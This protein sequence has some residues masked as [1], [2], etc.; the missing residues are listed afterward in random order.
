[1]ENLFVN[2]EQALA[3][4]ELGYISETFGF[5]WTDTT[6]LVY[7]NAIGNHSGVHLPVPLYQQAFKWF[8]KPENGSLNHL[9]FMCEFLKD[10]S[11]TYEQA[12][13]ASLNKLIEIIKTK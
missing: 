10:D 8:R 1:M 4:R 7:D 13:L 3:L 11:V 5:Y 2:Y 12:E 9:D 6:Q